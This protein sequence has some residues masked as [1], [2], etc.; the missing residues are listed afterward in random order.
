MTKETVR[1]PDGVVESVEAV[2][3]DGAFESKSEFYRFAAEYVLESIREE[4]DPETIDFEEILEELNE[5]H[6]FEGDSTTRGGVDDEFLGAALS[7][8]KDGMR[9]RF[10]DAEEFIDEEYAT[11]DVEAVV[12]EEWL[13][14]YRE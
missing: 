6:E 12:L 1:Y 2:I 14:H 4:Y 5:A 13:D 11:T 3:E 9:E 8:R 10:D 7:V